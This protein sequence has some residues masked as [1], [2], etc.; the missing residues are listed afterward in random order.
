MSNGFIKLLVSAARECHIAELMDD[1]GLDYEEAENFVKD[2]EKE[3]VLAN[4]LQRAVKESYQRLFEE[5]EV[6]S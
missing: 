3:D 2:I 4:D 6:T 1:L 5:Y